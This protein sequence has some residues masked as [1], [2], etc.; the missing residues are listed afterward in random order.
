MRF[1][2]YVLE[3]RRFSPDSNAN[4]VIFSQTHS[5]FVISVKDVFQ[6][7]FHNSP[8]SVTSQTLALSKPVK[9]PPYLCDVNSDTSDEF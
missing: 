3:S 7:L 4:L 5:F 9:P 8:N 2:L 1:S 6:A